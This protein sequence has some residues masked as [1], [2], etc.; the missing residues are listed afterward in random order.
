M[1]LNEG[2]V[3]LSLGKIKR[4]ID[5][6]TEKAKVE[7]THQVRNRRKGTKGKRGQVKKDKELK[8]HKK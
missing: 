6:R 1:R 4:E 7:M 8:G 3:Y 2:E 5:V